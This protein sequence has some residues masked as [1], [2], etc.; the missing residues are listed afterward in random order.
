[1]ATKKR[2]NGEGTIYFSEREQRWWAEIT[3]ID[4]DG[5]KRRKKWKSKKQSEVE[6]KL[7]EFKKQLLLL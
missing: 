3:W 5:N 6:V 1:M 4:A 2:A 7:A